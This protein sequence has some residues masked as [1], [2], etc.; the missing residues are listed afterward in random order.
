VSLGILAST[1]ATTIMQVNA[2][3]LMGGLLLACVG[4]A[5]APVAALPG[6]LRAVA[7][8]SPVYWALAGMRGVVDA[9]FGLG[10]VL[11]PLAVLAGFTA[12]AVLL[13]LGRYRHDEEKVFYV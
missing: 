1:F 7:P 5:L 2:F 3:T 4:G 12:L 8:V 11:V 13:A 9:G 6:W 10:Q